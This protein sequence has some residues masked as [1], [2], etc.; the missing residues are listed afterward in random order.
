MSEEYLEVSGIDESQK[1]KKLKQMPKPNMK[2]EGM[3]EGKIQPDKAWKEGFKKYIDYQS[4]IDSYQVPFS[5][6]RQYQDPK[7]YQERSHY[8]PSKDP[9]KHRQGDWWVAGVP[10]IPYAQIL[11]E[12]PVTN[13]F[14][15]GKLELRD[16][17]KMQALPYGKIMNKDRFIQES[18]KAMDRDHT[19]HMLAGI[20]PYEKNLMREYIYSQRNE[21]PHFKF[22]NLYNKQQAASGAVNYG[23]IKKDK[24]ALSA[25]KN[26]YK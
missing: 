21:I 25:G 7:N 2:L 8:T 17:N 18:I 4:L 3:R 11:E 10:V 19:H 6:G 22:E 26:A 16:I 24:S 5:S 13:L 9:L 12:Q 23:T 14:E 20:R 1:V 15:P